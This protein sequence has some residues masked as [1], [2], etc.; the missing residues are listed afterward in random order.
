M[1]NLTN[2]KRKWDFST[3]LEMIES[4]QRMGVN[5]WEL[6]SAICEFY[7]IFNVFANAFAVLFD[8]LFGLRQILRSILTCIEFC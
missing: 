4:K 3:L 2:Q 1:A 8:P 5:F 6:R 7:W